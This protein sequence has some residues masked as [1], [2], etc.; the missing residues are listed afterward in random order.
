MLEKSGLGRIAPFRVLVR[1]CR[2]VPDDMH[3]GRLAA[4]GGMELKINFIGCPFFGAAAQ[5]LPNTTAQVALSVPGGASQ[6][7]ILR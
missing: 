1:Q 5:S 3:K 4:R 2:E 7:S 6:D